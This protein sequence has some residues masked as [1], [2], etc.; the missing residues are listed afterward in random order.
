MADT[1]APTFGDQVY[2]INQDPYPH[3]FKWGGKKYVLEPEKKVPVPFEAMVLWAG[4]PR[5][6]DSMRSFR[7]GAS[8]SF[9]PDRDS[10]VRRLT[11]KYGGDNDRVF[12]KLSFKDLDD[13]KITTV[14]DDPEGK[15][16]LT[17]NVTVMQ[18]EEQ[19]EKIKALEDKLARVMATLEGTP[20]GHA[21]N[22]D[23]PEPV[24][25]ESSSEI[26]EDTTGTGSS[27][28]GPGKKTS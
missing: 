13:N 11:V 9:I 25:T 6:A 18:N 2:V 15:E 24:N 19:A 22:P 7:E 14:I 21:A 27:S 28:K 23:T 8:V 3:T 16:V 12:P 4:D 26:P 1:V 17:A 10:E 20:A 5:S